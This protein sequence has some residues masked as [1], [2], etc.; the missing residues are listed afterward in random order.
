[1]C[2]SDLEVFSYGD[3]SAFGYACYHKEWLRDKWHNVYH[4]PH[5][6]P[7]TIRHIVGAPNHV[8]I[9]R[10]TFYEKI[11]KHNPDL[12]VVDDY[13]LIIRTILKYRWVHIPEMMYIQY[14]NN[15][16]DNFTFHRNA[17]IQYIVPKIRLSYEHEIHERFIELGVDD[18]IF[19]K[20]PGHEKDWMVNSFKYPVLEHIYYAKDQDDNNPC[21]SIV[22]PTYN[23][24]N[25]LRRALVSIFSQTYQNFEI[26]LV[27]DKSPSL[28]QFIRGY[29]KAKDNRMKWYNLENQGGP[30]G[31][32]PRNYALKMMCKTK[33]V[34]YLDDDNFWIKD[35]LNH[36]VE[37]IRKDKDL[38]F[39]FSS[40]LIDDKELIFDIPRKGR[41]DTS[42]VVH[43]FDLVVKN[44]LWKDR[45]EDSYSHDW[46]FF[47]R[48]S[49]EFSCKWK[50]TKHCTLVYNTE[51]NGQ[52]YDQLMSM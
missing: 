38:E 23:R 48:I 45:I 20:S 9:W 41:I 29:E 36:L 1:V 22:V 24:P 5:V 11:G 18:D 17:L 16:G 34:A 2:S 6:N 49:N 46:S 4:V 7:K 28:E 27:G 13:E 39:V 47:N 42:C 32:L 43:K 37:E 10:R 19:M 25:H 21:I 31:H 35:H 44:G 50:A 14:R 52:S 8:R 51:F 12:P 30:G 33:W 40:M 3:F 26:L 15:G